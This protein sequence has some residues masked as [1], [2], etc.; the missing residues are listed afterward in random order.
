MRTGIEG[1]NYRDLEW[2]A[3]HITEGLYFEICSR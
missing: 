3:L 1:P 2:Y